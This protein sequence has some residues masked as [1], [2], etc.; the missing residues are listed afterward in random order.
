VAELAAL[1]IRICDDT[2]LTIPQ[3]HAQC[4]RMMRD[5]LGLVVI[6]YLQLVRAHERKERRDLDVGTISRGLKH[7][8]L[9]LRIPVISVASLSRE[10]ERR[11]DKRPMLSDLRESG[12]IESDADIVFFLHREAIYRKNLQGGEFE[13]VTEL[14]CAK[15]RGGKTGSDLLRFDGARTRFT[16]MRAE[17]KTKYR[18]ATK[19]KDGEDGWG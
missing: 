16:D 14:I 8:A 17:D 19:G 12:S 4:R 18:Q 15:N 6:D 10:N 11:E 7:L 9:D 1:P 3:I 2:T 13:S 5:G